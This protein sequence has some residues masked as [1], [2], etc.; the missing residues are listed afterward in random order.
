MIRR[1]AFALAFFIAFGFAGD[2][3]ANSLIPGAGNA[4]FNVKVK[5]LVDMRFKNV[6]RQQYDLS[7]GAAAMA[8][9]L[10]Y[11]Y[12]DDTDEQEII[13]GILEFGDEQKI[14]KDGFSML[15]LKKF[16][17]RAGYVGQG[18][19]IEQ[20]AA[21]AR[22]Q[23]PVL[24]LVDTR[25]YNHFVV[26]KGI[27]G[28]EVYIADPAFGNRSLP[29]EDFEEGWSNVVLVFLSATNGG[30]N[31]FTLDPKLKAQKKF[32]QLLLERGLYHI[33]PGANEF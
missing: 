30:N 15:E 32:V 8:T 6:V 24:T 9:L 20:A 12:G 18:Y 1:L 11:F 19:R 16:G 10:K 28:G 13:K 21:L 27:E 31:A 22:L 29:L 23:I 3:L 33:R 2:V 17:E 4:R 26:I 14:Q 25:G 7:C 5:S